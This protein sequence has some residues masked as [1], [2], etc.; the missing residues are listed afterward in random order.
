MHLVVII[1]GSPKNTES[2]T[3]T[4][5]T[6]NPHHLDATSSCEGLCHQRLA[7]Q[8]ASDHGHL[9]TRTLG[10][11]SPFNM[12]ELKPFDDPWQS[13][14]LEAYSAHSLGTSR[15]S[16]T[17]DEL[18]CPMARPYAVWSGIRGS[19]QAARPTPSRRRQPSSQSP[20]KGRQSGDD[21]SLDA[22]IDSPAAADWVALPG[23]GGSGVPP[24]LH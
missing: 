11:F 1:H 14:R 17:M 22:L 7:T 6:R 23:A 5:T 13:R 4:T 18:D 9:T 16:R 19:Q 2:P 15:T 20:A 10:R 12:R 21:C 8:L 24:A 3:T